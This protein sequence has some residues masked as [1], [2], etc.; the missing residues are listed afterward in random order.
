[1][2]LK[3][4][5]LRFF[6]ILLSLTIMIGSN[7]VPI[8]FGMTRAMVNVL[9]IFLSTLI[10]WLT[11]SINWPSILCIFA[12][13]MIPQLEGF[14]SIFQNVFA[15]NGVTIMF[16][17]ST[18]ICTYAISTTP[19]FERVAV[20]FISSKL[21]RHSAWGFTISFFLAVLVLGLF[22]SP[23]ILFVVLLPVL[24][25]IFKIADIK[26]GDK[27]G[28]MLMMGFAFIV[29]I[30]SGMTPIS[31]VFCVI[32]CNT[33][34]IDINNAKYM[35]MAI[36]CG[37]ILITI[38]ILL[39]RFILR[40]DMSKLKNI[41]VSSFKNKLEPVQ[42]EEIIDVTIFA[43]V[44]LMWI[45]PS[46]ITSAQAMVTILFA[47]MSLMITIG[48]NR[49]M[50]SILGINNEKMEVPALIFSL[51]SYGCYIASIVFVA[52]GK[53]Q[54]GILIELMIIA[55]LLISMFVSIFTNIKRIKKKKQY[56]SLTSFILTCIGLILI[57]AMQF[58]YKYIT[59]ETVFDFV[60]NL[61]KYTNAMPPILGVVLLSIIQVKGKSLV[62]LKQAFKEGIPWSSI[63]M[64]AGTLA[65]GSA[66]TN[67]N[68]GLKLYLKNSLMSAIQTE[69]AL[70]LVLLFVVWAILQTNV[71]SN[72][73]TA[74]LVSTVAT[75][76]LSS[77]TGTGINLTVV[78]YIIGMLSS[79]AFATPSS[80]PH[81]S[82][83][84][85]SGYT[86]TKQVFLY[87]FILMIFSVLISGVGYFI[88][89]LIM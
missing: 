25:G 77:Y 45:V 41:D 28:A 15:D 87:G 57:I 68:I 52:I 85:S 75:S 29:S 86:N 17:I 37:L 63:I 24:D 74:I 1:M 46:V 42:T 34:G 79:F 51:F 55:I 53:E 6:I 73:V 7:F 10:L 65:I 61:T 71:S 50:K 32:A 84:G 78:I 62:D 9:G 76:I 83:A 12:L 59:V 67:E 5:Y 89:T 40:P 19:F 88:G 72:M 64:C 27:V 20:K 54:L 43:F 23:T 31:H 81:I 49:G 56:C 47:I 36:P 80:M 48:F 3:N 18:F 60:K 4:K 39:F 35:L 70:I 11:I 58:V 38:M 33:A 2:G 26:K 16:L 30:S 69:E 21:A 8:P 44:V 13:G 22:I 82:L 66:L 14:K